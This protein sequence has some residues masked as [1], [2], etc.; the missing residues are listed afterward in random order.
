MTA[1]AIVKEETQKGDAWIKLF[2]TEFE[3]MGF[4]KVFL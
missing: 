2:D 1:S 3:S 4:T